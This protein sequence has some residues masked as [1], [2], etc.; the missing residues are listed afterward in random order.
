M[1][2]FRVAIIL[3]LLVLSLSTSYTALAS[4]PSQANQ[5]NAVLYLKSHFNQT[6]GLIYE[7]EDTSIIPVGNY[8]YSHSQIYFIYSD[9][10][11]A[12]WALKPY[13]PQI[14]DKINNT[15]LSYNV[16]N[17]DFYEVLFGIKIPNQMQAGVQLPV[18]QSPSYVVL[19]E[20]HN[21]STTLNSELNGDTLIYQ[22][23]NSYLSGN[24][25]SA[26]QY[27][28]KAYDMW[29][30]KGVYDDA[31]QTNHAYSNYKLAL[32]LFAS[33]VLNLTISDYNAIENKLWSMQQINGGITSLAELNGNPIGSANTETTSISLLPYYEDLI[34]TIQ[35][36]A[37]ITL[38]PTPPPI[39]TPTNTPT[40]PHIP[41]S[42][43]SPTETPSSSE[44]WVLSWEFLI[45]I[46]AVISVVGL[47]V[48][49]LIHKKK[50]NK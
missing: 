21:S 10:L 6:I 2:L 35:S 15:I 14:S 47:C 34:K 38:T 25:T 42:T 28:Y 11:L 37:Q 43:S 12:E 30:G 7:S 49:M 19:A 41:S 3:S 23:L 44:D 45:I 32:L 18:E 5:D 16:P 33:K 27:F 29:D 50:A 9:N 36:I 20:F 40:T 48:G 8:T 22:S 24:K 13:E 39:S 26:N 4:Q 1:K 17:P 31:T 46:L